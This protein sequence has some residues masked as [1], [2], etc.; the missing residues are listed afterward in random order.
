MHAKKKSSGHTTWQWRNNISLR[1]FANSKWHCPK[2]LGWNC[3]GLD[4]KCLLKLWPL[5]TSC[6]GA[7]WGG[8]GPHPPSPPKQKAYWGAKKWQPGTSWEDKTVDGSRLEPNGGVW[9]EYCMDWCHPSRP[10]PKV[11]QVMSP[12]T[13]SIIF[14]RLQG[15]RLF[16]FFLFILASSLCKVLFQ[17][18]NCLLILF[19]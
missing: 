10:C 14:F 17:D 18:Q 3:N 11:L 7:K 2:G 4:T 19:E 15:L 8:N 5:Q 13:S 12:L 9:L 1:E 6:G 16:L